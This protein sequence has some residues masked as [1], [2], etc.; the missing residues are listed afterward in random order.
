LPPKE[1]FQRLLLFDLQ[2]L[3]RPP[4]HE[5]PQNSL[6]AFEALDLRRLL[7]IYIF[8]D[9]NKWSPTRRGK[10]EKVGYLEGIF[11]AIISLVVGLLIQAL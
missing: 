9:L 6:D 10:R 1:A 8:Q 7:L 2:E 4:N 11:L 3:G 5:V